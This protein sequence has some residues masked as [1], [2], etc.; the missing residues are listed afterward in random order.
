MMPYV[1]ATLMVTQCF[2]LV[3]IGFLV[4]PFQLLAV[5]G[6]VFAVPDGNGLNPLLQH[7]VMT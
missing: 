1:T 5:S 3:L 7:P 4:S 6:E 2:F